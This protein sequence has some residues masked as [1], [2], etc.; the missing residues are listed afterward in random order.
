MSGLLH[1][2]LA[3]LTAVLEMSLDA[4]LMF[5]AMIVVVLSNL[6]CQVLFQ[7]PSIFRTMLSSRGLHISTHP[8]RNALASRYLTEIATIQFSVISVDMENEYIEQLMTLKR[9]LYLFRSSNQAS[10]LIT[11]PFLA[12]RYESWQKVKHKEDQSFYKFINLSLPERSRISVLTDDAS[13]LEGIKIFQ[14]DDV[15]AIQVPMDAFRIGL[16]T[17]QRLTSVLTSEGELH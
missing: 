3:A 2:P 1:A 12:Q 6:T 11:Q 14:G 5:P 17:R 8:L 4:T 16:V 7:Q 13:L 9:K 10:Y 15:S